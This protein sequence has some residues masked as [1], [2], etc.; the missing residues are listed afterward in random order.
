MILE[1]LDVYH[2][3]SSVHSPF[4]ESDNKKSFRFLS[5]M[6]WESRKGWDVLLRA[7]FDEF[8]QNDRDKVSLYILTRLD[9]KAKDKYEKFLEEYQAF[10]GINDTSLLPS[11]KILDTL[12]PFTK[13]PSVYKSA[14]CFVLPSHGEGWGLP[15]IEAMSMG[16]P[17]IGTNWS[18]TTGFMNNQNSLLVEVTGMEPAPLEGHSWATPDP[19]LLRQHMRTAFENGPE[20]IAM[21]ERARKDVE[22]YF[23]LEAVAEIAIQKLREI[24]PHLLEVRQ[25]KQALK[26]Q[27]DSSRHSSS[28]SIPPTWYSANPPSWSTNSWSSGS[29]TGQE[30]LDKDGKKK[31]KIKII[32]SSSK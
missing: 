5:I 12:V 14:D 20:I 4:L 11:V 7:Y 24:Q 16:L 31:Y 10:A 9:D 8:R 29:S 30:F 22:R 25:S 26:L 21:A 27:E 1:L 13:L 2:F 6:K 17:T 15:L 19:V 32:N 3:D 23:S 18:G 28:S